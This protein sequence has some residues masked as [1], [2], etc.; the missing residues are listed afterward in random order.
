[1]YSR[2]EIWRISLPI[3]VSLFVQNLIN[4]TDTA[5]MGRVGQVELGASALAGVLY[6]AFYMVTFG[7]STGAQILMA[8]RN[9][10]AK[11]GTLGPIMGQGILFLEIL[12]IILIFAS[13]IGTPQMLKG[14]ISSTA[15]CQA[16]EDY[17]Q[18]RIFGLLFTSI[19]VMF[20]AFFVGTTQTRTL[21]LNSVVMVL[22][23]ILF[24]YTLIFGKFGFPAMGIAG[25]AIGSS[26]A[27]LV[28]VIFFITYTWRKVDYRKYGLNHVP[29]IRIKELKHIMSISLWTMIQNFIS[30]ST[31]F[32]FFLFIEHLGERPLAISNIIRS[33]SS[34]PF[35]TVMAF[36]S[37]CGSLVSNRIG[38]G[39]PEEVL[40]LI[41]RHIRLCTCI[42]LPVIAL[43]ALFPHGVLR[44]YTDIPELV[45]ASIP[46]LWVLCSAYFIL[47]PGNIYF[48]SVSGTGNTQMAFKLELAALMIYLI[49]IS[50][51]ILI[52]KADV[53]ICWFAEHLYALCIGIASYLYLYKGNWSRKKI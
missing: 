38:A 23:N 45:E 39:H 5:F 41:G 1:M 32:L 13:L 30:L 10:E 50:V 49:F 7:F 51:V 11:Y 33:V 48:Q 52:L 25:A 46:T 4:I 19:G 53:A 47:I 42:V 34:L 24:N 17:M 21:T 31:W 16:G 40:R 14:L 44:I 35:M 36:A 8:R 22:S 18:Y 28:S 2:K 26:L 43:I 6:L 12:T 3:L 29:G 37:T 15:V 27:E 20:R 9:G